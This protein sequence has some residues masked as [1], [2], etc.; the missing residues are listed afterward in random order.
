M[1]EDFRFR[2]SGF[3]EGVGE[4]RE[5]ATVQCARPQMPLLV[6]G[7]S[8]TDHDGIV[9]GKDGGGYG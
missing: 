8:E 2:A 3:F 4:D 9:P 1:V 6:G 5:P 7:L